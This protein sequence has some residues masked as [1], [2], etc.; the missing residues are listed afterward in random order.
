MRKYLIPIYIVLLTIPLLAQ[1]FDL[2]LLPEDTYIE[3]REGEDGLHL[4][5]NKK[6]DINSILLTES[7]EDPTKERSVFALRD[8]DENITVK[9]EDRLLNGILLDKSY[10]FLIDSTPEENEVFGL[11]FHIYIPKGVSYGYPWSREG[12]IDMGEGSWLNIRTF[13]KK[14]GNYE[15][16]FKDN[17][18][19]IRLYEEAIEEPIVEAPEDES[20]FE[21]I[22]RET[23]GDYSEEY[24]GDGAV[25]KI[26][27]ILDRY[28]G[29]D[30]DLALV[31]DSTVSMKDDVEFIRLKLIPLVKDKIAGFKSVRIGVMLYRDYKEAY[32]TRKFDF[33]DNFDKAQMILDSI[34]V[35]GGRDIPEAVFEALYAAQ[36]TMDWQNSEKVI[37]Q[38]G[39]APP[40]PEPRGD[41]T[42]EMVYEESRSKNISIY[43]ILLKDEKRDSVTK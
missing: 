27:E 38:V 32:L 28:K 41:I 4:F 3:S 9:D 37:V 25:T 15:G 23:A 30:V 8:F 31:I 7:T 39:D 12:Q 36:T 20:I 10:N 11:A 2:T 17:P 5:V 21:E 19:I 34:K 42:S 29:L 33:V 1:E 43:P 14:F 24:D 13:P 26:G 18:F 16:G 6:G 40:H 35:Q 22:A